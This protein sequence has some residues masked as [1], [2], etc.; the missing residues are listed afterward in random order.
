MFRS[1]CTSAAMPSATARVITAHGS[2]A[3]SVVG[4]RIARNASYAASA[5][6]RCQAFAIGVYFWVA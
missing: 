3:A 1:A 6:S 5:G 4:V 2:S